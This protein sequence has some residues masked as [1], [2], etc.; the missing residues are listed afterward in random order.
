MG[1]FV[2][3]I[4]DWHNLSV[5]GNVRSW[6][7]DGVADSPYHDG[8]RAALRDL[9]RGGDDTRYIK[10][11]LAHVWA[12]AG[13]GKDWM[14]SCLI[15]LAGHCSYFG[16]GNIDVKLE[17]AYGSFREWLRSSGKVSSITEFSKSELK[18]TS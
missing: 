13:F 18:I 2:V 17:L 10:I 9:T 14:A 5:S 15:F 4:Q 7:C 16:R 11:D 1:E 3:C 8:G 6:P 12:I